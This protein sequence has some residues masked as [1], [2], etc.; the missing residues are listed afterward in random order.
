MTLSLRQQEIA[1]AVVSKCTSAVAFPC[2]LFILYEIYCDSRSKGTNSIKRTILG[3][4]AIDM[5]ASFAW[6]LSSWAVPRGSFPLAAGN[7]A[8][9]NFQGFLLQ[10]AIGA[11]LYNCSLS[12]YYVLI[13]KY[14][15]TDVRLRVVEMWV[16]VA[17]LT[18]AVGS[19]I[20]L[21]PLEQYNP[22]GSVC[23]VIGNPQE[24]DDSRFQGIGVP[25][26]RGKN[27]WI[28]GLSLF[29]GPLW[30]CIVVSICSMVMIY[31]EVKRTSKRLERYS[32]SGISTRGRNS[33]DDTLQVA[34]QAILY[35]IAFVLTWMPSTL[36]SIAHWFNWTNFYL[37]FAAGFCEPLQGVWN[38]FHLCPY[39]LV[40][41]T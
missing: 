6:F 5:L 40:D 25:C 31:Q 38:S 18:F 14:R 15:W 32:I 23:W 35:S 22:T 41:Q 24:C 8:S 16:H 13:L 33:N 29:Y 37:D 30:V 19:S 10:L 3:V 7:R 12:L 17:V 36:W 39:S 26:V 27:A 11:P 34:T 2:N 1:L 21:L 9:C 20:L 4:T 28:Y